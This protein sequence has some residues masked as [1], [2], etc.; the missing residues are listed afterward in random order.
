MRL[1]FALLLAALLLMALGGGLVPVSAQSDTGTMPNLHAGAF[2]ALSPGNQKIVQ[3]LHDAQ[4]MPAPGAATSATA[5]RVYSLDEIAAMKQSGRG[6]GGVFEEIQAQGQLQG[7]KNLGQVVSGKYQ[8][9]PATTATATSARTT[10]SVTGGG[11]GGATPGGSKGAFDRLSPGNQKIA[12]ALH[13][14][15]QTPPTGTASSST[16]PKAYSLDEIAAMKQSG[17]GWGGV[18]KTMKTQGQLQGAKN[19]GQVVSGKYGSATFTTIVTTASG[20]TEVVRTRHSGGSGHTGWQKHGGSESG[21]SGT[22]KGAGHGS[23]SRTVSRGA[24]GHRN[25]THAKADHANTHGRGRVK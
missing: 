25:V 15:Q 11:T 22:G 16:A 9:L 4:Q 21:P 8:P 18:F 3:A 23:S 7:A 6:W 14:A 5:P 10:S 19:L 20:R 17:Q 13:D 24:D 2:E 12:R 1:V